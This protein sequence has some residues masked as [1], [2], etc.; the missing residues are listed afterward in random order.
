MKKTSIL[1]LV[2]VLTL[3]IVSQVSAYKEETTSLPGTYKNELSNQAKLNDAIQLRWNSFQKKHIERNTAEKTI[4]YQKTVHQLSLKENNVPRNPNIMDRSGEL[5]TI[6]DY[7]ARRETSKPTFTPS[8][9]TSV[10][11]SR[12]IDYYIDGG[13]AGTDLLRNRGIKSSQYSVSVPTAPR[14]ATADPETVGTLRAMQRALYTPPAF[15][16][17]NQSM[18]SNRKGDY[19]RNFWSPFMTSDDDEGVEED[20]GFYST[21]AE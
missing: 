7:E 6:P 4:P 14:W 5:N 13:D 20:G 18:S 10:L 15:K 12:L 11:R 9:S 3:G 2:F 1:S 17:G 19:Y 21:E 16:T 8:N